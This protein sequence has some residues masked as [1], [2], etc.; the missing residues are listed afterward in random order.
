[1]TPCRQPRHRRRT[2]RREEFADPEIH[3]PVSDPLEHLRF[4]RDTIESAGSFTAVPGRGM[5]LIG[6]TALLA[7]AVATYFTNVL[8]SRWIAIWLSEALLAMLLA[9]FFMGRKARRAG[10]SLMS[11]PAKKF[12]TSFAP[13]MIVGALLTAI[14]L[15]AGV[16]QAIPPMWLMLYGTAVI[17]GGAFSVRIVP[18]MG[19]CFLALG[20]FTAFISAAWT[21]IYMAVG[22]GGLHLIFGGIVARRHGG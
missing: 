6:A 2:V 14:L 16:E 10:Q 7:C 19:V 17:T 18:V 9:L 8:T 15:R 12:A 1:M 13:P 22:F 11:G 20:I 3:P 21:N 5:V 4:I